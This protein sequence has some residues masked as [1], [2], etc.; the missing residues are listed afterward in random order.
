MERKFAAVVVA[1]SLVGGILASPA[2]A[3]PG[4]GEPANP[5]CFGQLVS[6]LA[7]QYGGI[8]NA[9]DAI[10]VTIQQGHSLARGDCGRTSG[11]T[12]AP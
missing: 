2:S 10:G 12:P 7:Q 8:S 6:G 9:A 1:T 4:V 5:S 11:F 3:D